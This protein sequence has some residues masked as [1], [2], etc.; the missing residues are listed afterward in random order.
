MK[1]ARPQGPRALRGS[2][3]GEKPHAWVTENMLSASLEKAPKAT[4]QTQ[5]GSPQCDPENVGWRPHQDFRVPVGAEG[6][7]PMEEEVHP[8]ALLQM[9]WAEGEVLA[10]NR[11]VALSRGGPKAILED[12]PARLE[13]RLEDKAER[14]RREKTRKLFETR[15]GMAAGAAPPQPILLVDPGVLSIGGEFK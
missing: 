11:E 5:N 13:A 4:L 15:T 10:P 2:R 12:R 6:D 7:E 8:E 1:S 9:G 3:E 14:A